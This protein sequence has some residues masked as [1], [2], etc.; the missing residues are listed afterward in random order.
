M[1]ILG[2]M[3]RENAANERADEL[4]KRVRELEKTLTKLI[5]RLKDAR[6]FEVAQQVLPHFKK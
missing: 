6:T 5:E 2:S 1:T 3:M 4:K